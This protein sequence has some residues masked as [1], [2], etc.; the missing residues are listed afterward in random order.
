M[1][2]EKLARVIEIGKGYG[3]EMNEGATE[4]ELARL[5]EAMGKLGFTIPEEYCDFLRVINGLE[6]NG[7]ALYGVDA[8]YLDKKPKQTGCGMVDGFESWNFDPEDTQRLYVGDKDISLYYY[9]QGKYIELDI[10]N[11]EDEY[12]VFHTIEDFLDYAFTFMIDDDDDVV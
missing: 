9:K 5:R 12:D 1:W 11:R 7:L 8:E 4:A 2:R 6:S 3:V 10:G